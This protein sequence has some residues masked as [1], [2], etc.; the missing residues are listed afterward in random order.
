MRVT[1]VG[2]LTDLRD[3]SK[4]LGN[5][6]V[7]WGPGIRGSWSSRVGNRIFVGLAT[8]ALPA[9]LRQGGGSAGSAGGSGE[10]GGGSGS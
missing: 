8:D 9:P 2:G 7:P 6:R 10:S 1:D 4:S 5:W 3:L